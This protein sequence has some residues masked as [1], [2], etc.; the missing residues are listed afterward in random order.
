MVSVLSRGFGALVKSLA[1]LTFTPV[2]RCSNLL[3]G[4]STVQCSATKWISKSHFS[5]DLPRRPLTAYI[6]YF[7]DQQ[8]A[9][10]KKNPEAK[11]AELA[12]IISAEWK[13]LPD[14]VRERYEVAAKSEQQT[15]KEIMKKHR[16]SQT[17]EQSEA[18]KAEGRSK[19]EK[20]TKRRH[21][22]ELS[23]LGK[24][25][26]PRSSFNIFMSEH[27]EEAKGN[28]LQSKM[29][30]LHDDWGILHSSQ[31]QAYIQLAEDDKI[32]Y[33]N[34]MK[35]WEENMIELGRIDLIRYKKRPLK[36]RA[37]KSETAASNKQSSINPSADP[38]RF[39]HGKKVGTNPSHN[40]K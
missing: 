4:L 20:R 19:R 7:I 13:E 36:L 8:A 12:K 30:S 32:R 18:L 22:K 37:Q 1:G 10:R 31:K 5:E 23:L 3:C 16:E 26:R 11:V 21:K 9:H 29:S 2:T 38:G 25:K 35:S 15:Y 28:T 6:R 39:T 33:E 40:E 34:E 17:R 27:F 24:P 14:S